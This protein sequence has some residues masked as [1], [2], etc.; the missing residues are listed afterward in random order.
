[1]AGRNRAIANL[2]REHWP[3]VLLVALA[4]FLRF[5]NLAEADFSHDEL[6]ALY[7]TQFDSLSELFE[8][9]IKVDGHPPLV[10][11][12]LYYWAPLVQYQEFWVKLPSVLLGLG[13]MFLVYRS[14]I[15]VNAQSRGELMPVAIIAF[16]E[17][18]LYHHQVAR[19]YAYGMFFVALSAYAYFAW[20]YRA[21]KNKYLLLFGLGA[22]LAAFTHY[23]ALLSVLLIGLH[24]IWRDRKN[25]KPWLWL[26]LAVLALFSPYLGTFWYQLQLGGVGQWLGTP[27]ADWLLNFFHYLFNYFILGP[28]IAAGIMLVLLINAWRSKFWEGWIWFLSVFLIAFLY[29]IFRNPVLQFSSLIFLSPFLFFQKEPHWKSPYLQL[30]LSA[31]LIW[32]LVADRAYFQY[33]QKA[34]P[35]EAARFLAEHQL[36]GEDLYYHWSPEKWKFYHQIDQQVP[37]GQYLE[38]LNTDSLSAEAFSLVVDHAAPGHWPLQLID[39][40][41]ALHHADFQFGF[42][43]FHFCRQS[44]KNQSTY[45]ILPVLENLALESTNQQYQ[46]L[47]E[48]LELPAVF[49]RYQVVLHFDSLAIESPMHLVFQVMDA[50]EQVAWYAHPID[51]NTRYISRALSPKKDGDYQW[52]ILLDKGNPAAEVQGKINLRLFPD[53]PLIY[54]LVQDF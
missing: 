13:S 4:A 30:V 23:L 44:P 16:S 14:S 1:M 7:R 31:L 38:S 26:G 21:R 19:P 47:S 28:Y 11:V 12:F 45:T 34:P 32:S 46:L 36:E 40:G 52:R 24:A 35:K 5:W 54:G 42:S 27:K 33:G 22:I 10:Q 17:L 29:S 25:P 50:E 48:D 49:D 37:A 15:F 43:L 41:Y 39:A 53:N 6:S 20:F 8:K 9:A 2:L 3:F 51:V 18:F